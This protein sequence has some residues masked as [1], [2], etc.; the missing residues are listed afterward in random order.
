[1]LYY[2]LK[3]SQSYAKLKSEIDDFDRESKF[4][5]PISHAEANKMHYLQAVMK[6]AIRLHSAIGISM[7]RYVHP[8][9]QKSTAAGILEGPLLV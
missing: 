3:N 2:L 9:E 1:M 8:G 7:P 6:E 4:S 5:N